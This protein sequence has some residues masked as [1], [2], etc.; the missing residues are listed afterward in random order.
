MIENFLGF[1]SN[2]VREL[3]LR[4]VR[5]FQREVYKMTFDSAMGVLIPMYE[6]EKDILLVGRKG[7]NTIEQIGLG[8]STTI[9][10]SKFIGVYFAS[11]AFGLKFRFIFC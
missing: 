9:C 3:C 1:D 6:K 2:S 11:N 7:D 4:D 5:N 8:P 10:L